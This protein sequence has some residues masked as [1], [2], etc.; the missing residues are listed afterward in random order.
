[1]LGRGQFVKF[2][3]GRSVDI[4]FTVRNATRSLLAPQRN[5]GDTITQLNSE[6]LTIGPARGE[7]G[8]SQKTAQVSK[9]DVRRPSI[10]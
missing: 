7:G 4:Q 2:I 9:P 6:N 1:M 8:A 10:T 3:A 5:R